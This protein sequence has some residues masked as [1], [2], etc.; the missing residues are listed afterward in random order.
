MSFEQCGRLALHVGVPQTNCVVCAPSRYYIEVLVEVKT[1][2]TLSYDRINVI[3]KL[4]Y[5]TFMIMVF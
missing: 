5:D 1:V 3:E 4:S 2:Y